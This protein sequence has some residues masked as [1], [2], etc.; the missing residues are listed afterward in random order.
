MKRYLLFVL[1]T[2][3]FWAC[4]PSSATILPAGKMTG[5]MWDIIQTDEF[6]TGYLA[7]DSSKNI[8]FE[9]MKMYQEVFSL[10]HVSDKEFFASFKYYAGKPNLFK[11]LID[12]L[13][14]KATREQRNSH[15]PA[16]TVT[17]VAPKLK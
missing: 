3:A 1:L 7:K 17:P 4:R 6:A 16:T 14:E 15:A 12:S 8:K 2:A 9:R 13:S 5:V 10:H 11:V